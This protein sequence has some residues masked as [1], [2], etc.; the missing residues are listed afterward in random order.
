[1]FREMRDS[2]V[3][4]SFVTCSA[5]NAERTVSYG[6]TAFPYCILKPAIRFSADHIFLLSVL[7]AWSCYALYVFGKEAGADLLSDLVLAE[8]IKFVVV[9]IDEYLVAE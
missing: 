8:I 7:R 3:K 4:A 9:G 6:R 5:F 2:A 1:M